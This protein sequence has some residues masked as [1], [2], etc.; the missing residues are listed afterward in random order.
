M[1]FQLLG[2]T[3]HEYVPSACCGQTPHLQRTDVC[4]EMLSVHIRHITVADVTEANIF[5]PSLLV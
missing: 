2:V 3:W 1:Q 4:G 5:G